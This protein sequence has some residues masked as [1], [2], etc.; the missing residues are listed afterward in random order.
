MIKCKFCSS[1]NDL[2]MEPYNPDIFGY[3]CNKCNYGEFFKKENSEFL[4]ECFTFYHKGNYITI[5][6]KN[7]TS[8]IE[9]INYRTLAQRRI[10]FNY[11]LSRIDINNIKG[12]VLKYITFS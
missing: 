1:S 12:K 5:W 3:I 9:I 6:N 11:S 4:E 8:V 10:E 2:E 7:N